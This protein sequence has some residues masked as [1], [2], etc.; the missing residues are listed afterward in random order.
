MSPTV[1]SIPTE[2]AP[3]T[4]VI[5]R[6]QGAIEP[7]LAFLI[8]DA[9]FADPASRMAVKARLRDRLDG[10]DPHGT[11]I[12]AIGETLRDLGRDPAALRL[13]P[14][15][16]LRELAGFRTQL[17]ANADTYNPASKP[18]PDA[19]FWP[20][21]RRNPAHDL[22]ATLPVVQNKAL[23]NR[24][25]PVGSA[26]SCFATE[27]AVALQ[28]RG[29]AYVRREEESEGIARGVI[30]SDYDAARVDARY[31]ANWGPLFNTPSFRQLAER[32]FG[33]RATPRLLVPLHR[34]PPHPCVYCDP[35]REGV[36]FVSPEA[37]AADYEQHL[38]SCREALQACRVF[39]L[40]LGLNE[41][42]EYVPDGSV[43]SRNPRGGALLPFIRP[44]VLTVAENVANI[45]R[46]VEIVR[47][48]NPDF[49]VILSVS[50][51]PLM[52]T[53][54]ARE[55]HV[56]SANAHSKAVLRTAAES[57]V[58]TV[59]DVHYF[60]SYELVTTCTR[61]AWEADQRHVS[62]HAV[63]RVMALFDAMFVDPA[64]TPLDDEPHLVKES[65]LRS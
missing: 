54:R 6:R 59:P 50:P 4:F 41:C 25:T 3:P 35:F 47:A 8:V 44:R 16:L 63:G 1:R 9:I 27:I 65:E 12:A 45:R 46:F 43:L 14:A 21:P 52:A 37:Y 53:T 7:P 19:V 39:V 42:W 29:F 33:E 22:Y 26:G 13:D 51:V 31:C 40:T 24:R 23:V 48:H 32:A 64:E 62:A 58:D 36:G 10:G 61:D 55:H 56:I 57:L 34:G 18:N 38:A 5:G 49:T 2:A 28:R 17:T 60:P 11:L 15:H 20:N 30:M